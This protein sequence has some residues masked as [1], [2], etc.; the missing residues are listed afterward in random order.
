LLKQLF[1][2]GVKVSELQKKFVRSRG[3][4]QSRLAKLGLIDEVFSYGVKHSTYM[5]TKESDI[6]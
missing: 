6:Y 5:Q 3:S 2:Q 4:I 1:E